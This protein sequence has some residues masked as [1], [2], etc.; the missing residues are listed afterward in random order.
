MNTEL[1]FKRLFI[2]SEIQRLK[3]FTEDAVLMYSGIEFEYYEESIYFPP[4]ELKSKICKT[5]VKLHVLIS[6]PYF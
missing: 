5:T 2:P 6:S 3:C 4:L 1:A